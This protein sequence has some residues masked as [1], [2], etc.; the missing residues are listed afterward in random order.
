[1]S[2]YYLAPSSLKGNLRFIKINGANTT[3]KISGDYFALKFL[4]EISY[5]H[6]YVNMLHKIY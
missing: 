3:K 1:M 5:I 4:R 2:D 6:I